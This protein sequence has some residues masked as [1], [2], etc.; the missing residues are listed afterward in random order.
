MDLEYVNKRE[1][2]QKRGAG[3]LAQLPQGRVGVIEG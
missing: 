1:R 3:V 2:V